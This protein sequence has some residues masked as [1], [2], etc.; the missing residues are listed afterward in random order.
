MVKMTETDIAGKRYVMFFPVSAIFRLGELF[1]RE[2]TIDSVWRA[3]IPGKGENA[4]SPEVSTRVLEIA[5]VLLAAG[6][7]AARAE[8][9]EAPDAPDAEQLAAL[10]TLPEY[11]R[12]HRA[13]LD[14]IA[15][16]MGRSVRTEENQKK[17][18]TMPE[19]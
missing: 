7:A 1:G 13:A 2:N 14:A 17:T 16:G 12:L 10:L 3:L 9:G 4:L 8:G 15:D 6:T 19:S 11:V 18:E 5:A